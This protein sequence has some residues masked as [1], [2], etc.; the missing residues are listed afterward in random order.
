[1]WSIEVHY[2]VT[3]INYTGMADYQHGILGLSFA[4]EPAEETNDNMFYV[5]KKEKHLD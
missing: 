1:M 3:L 2:E 4:G 5:R